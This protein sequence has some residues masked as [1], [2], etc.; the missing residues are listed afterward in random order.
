[1]TAI[2]VMRLQGIP[3]DRLKR[4][5]GV[6]DSYFRATIGNGFTIPVVAKVIDRILLAI[7][8]TCGLHYDTSDGE[9]A[10]EWIPAGS[11]S[12][13]AEPA[14]KKPRHSRH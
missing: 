5:M 12:Q 14:K 7:G 10:L 11:A 6:P 8:V 2:E 4:P 13:Q 3:D 9:R 1:M